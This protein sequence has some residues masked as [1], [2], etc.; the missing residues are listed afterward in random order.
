V[1]LVAV[2]SLGLAPPTAWASDADPTWKPIPKA[3]CRPGDPVETGLQGQVPRA[4][5]ASG[6]AA[7]GYACNLKLVGR[8]PSNG[9]A[10]FD[11]Y[12]DCGYYSDNPG[13]LGTMADTGTVVLDLSD[14]KA[15]EKTDY[16]TARAMRDTGESMRVNAERGLLVANHYGNGHGDRRGNGAAYPWLAV[17]DVS[18]DCRHPRLLADVAMPRGRGH[19]G[20]FSPD[21]MTYYMSNYGSRAVVPVDLSDPTQPRELAKWPYAVHGGSIS[22]DGTRGYL[23]AMFPGPNELLTVDTSDVGPGLPNAG[24]IISRLPL[25]DTQGNQNAYRLDYG[26]HPY[27]ISFGEMPAM[28]HAPCSVPRRQNFDAARMVDIADEAHPKIVARFLNEVADP[29]NCEKVWGDFQTTTRGLDRADATWPVAAAA[30]FQYDDHYCTPD[31]LHDP[32]I[33]ACAQ[34]MSGLRVYDIRDPHRPR[35][36]AYY[37]TGTV[38]P[39]DETVDLAIAR[40][41][42]RRDLRQIWFVTTFGGFHAVEFESGLWPFQDSDPCPGGYDHHQAQYDPDYRDCLARR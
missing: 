22:E 5:R 10:S 39:G 6:R 21:G 3:E 32:T 40:P 15:P 29:A 37:N 13:A 27:L 20:W 41:V 38:S 9:F 14:P 7:K 17:Y 24:R 35:E 1:G 34:Y 18:E 11:T 16:L 42:I 36:I 25:P 4:D 31:R 26:G 19:E 28:P 30:L 8:Y 2:V 23:A 33:L 12:Q